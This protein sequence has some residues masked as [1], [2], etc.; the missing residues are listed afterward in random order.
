[1]MMAYRQLNTVICVMGR[2]MV[3]VG[4]DQ[5]KIDPFHTTVYHSFVQKEH[6]NVQMDRNA[7][8][9]QRFVMKSL[10]VKMILMRILMSVNFEN[11]PKVEL[12]WL[13][14]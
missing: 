11:V 5:M 1:M 4:M 3:D 10:T 13:V 9:K 7:L 8:Q 6:G 14:S 12:N 2:H